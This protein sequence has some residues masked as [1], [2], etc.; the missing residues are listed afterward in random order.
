VPPDATPE[1]VEKL[2]ATA[3]EDKKL[4]DSLRQRLMQRNVA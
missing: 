1:Q 3:T 2:V 4:L